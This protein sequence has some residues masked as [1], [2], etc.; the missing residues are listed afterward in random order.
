MWIYIHKHTKYTYLLTK[1]KMI[2]PCFPEE[3][4]GQVQQQENYPMEDVVACCPS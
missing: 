1:E 3:K 4:H 2:V